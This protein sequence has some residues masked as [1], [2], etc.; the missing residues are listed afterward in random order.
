MGNIT[1]RVHHGDGAYSVIP[2]LPSHDVNGLQ[3][4]LRYS[5]DEQ[6]RLVAASVVDT[7]EYLLS[8]NIS[9]KEAIRRVRE[10]RNSYQGKSH[11]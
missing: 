2:S 9:T 4:L 7:F 8:H 6:S 1:R 11:D 10:M 3:W 5:K